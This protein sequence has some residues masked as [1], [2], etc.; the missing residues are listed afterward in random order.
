MEPS[1]AQ[2][3]IEPR[4]LLV[5]LEQQMVGNTPRCATATWHTTAAAVAA[6]IVPVGVITVAPIIMTLGSSN[7][8]V[9]QTALG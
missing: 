3:D 6:I 9:L 8:V 7:C 4:S 5:V 2:D 1:L